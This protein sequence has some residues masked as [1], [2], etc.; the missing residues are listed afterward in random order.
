MIIKKFGATIKKQMKIK[1]NKNGEFICNSCNIPF[2]DH[3]G[4]IL[5][6]EKLTKVRGILKKIIKLYSEA[7]KEIT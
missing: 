2:A 7:L 5:T 3:G 1:K 4:L 6:C